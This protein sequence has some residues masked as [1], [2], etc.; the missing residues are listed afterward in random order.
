[1]WQLVAGG[2]CKSNSVRH[3]VRSIQMV[4]VSTCIRS[5]FKQTPSQ[6]LPMFLR[7]FPL[8]R[9]SPVYP[10]RCKS[11]SLWSPCAAE[12]VLRL[13]NEIGEDAVWTLSTA[14]AGNGVQQL[15]DNNLQT[16][17]QS[18]GLQPHL[19]TLEFNKQVNDI[20]TS[21]SMFF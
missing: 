4:I 12:H 13:V 14:K 11:L 3:L 21:A 10:R 2:S 15:R 9:W 19:I 1:M 5:K 7:P 6:C 16:F 17:W 20:A 8:Q 18:D